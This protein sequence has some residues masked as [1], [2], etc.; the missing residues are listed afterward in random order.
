MISIEF[1]ELNYKF[2]F[3]LMRTLLIS[4]YIWTTGQCW[5]KAISWYWISWWITGCLQL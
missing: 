3:F 4:N 5:P 1:I 2:M